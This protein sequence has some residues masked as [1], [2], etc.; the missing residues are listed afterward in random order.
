MKIRLKCFQ[1]YLKWR[2]ILSRFGKQI[3][4]LSLQIWFLSASY[5]ILVSSPI[6][7]WKTSK[8]LF[9]YSP[10]SFFST[11]TSP[12]DSSRNLAHIFW[13]RAFRFSCSSIGLWTELNFGKESLLQEKKRSCWILA[14][15]NQSIDITRWQ[16]IETAEEDNAR[17]FS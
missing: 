13:Q 11:Q 3:N 8:I 4:F 5:G 14:Q 6:G 7:R 15:Q 1:A 12:W 9:D 10:N 17:V 16:R 2:R